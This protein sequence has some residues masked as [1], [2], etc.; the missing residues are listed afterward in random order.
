M[1]EP[2]PVLQE[3]VDNITNKIRELELENTQLWV[4]L[5]CTKQR[6]KVLED[7]GKQVK[8]EFMSNKKILRE[9]LGKREWVGDALVGAN[10]E[11][12]FCNN[13]LDQAYHTIKDLEK[14]VEMSNM[15][16]KEAKEEYEAQ[17]LELRTT[18]KDCR[19]LLAHEKLER[20]NVYRGFFCEQF[21]LRRAYEQIK[22]LKKWIYDQAYLEL[23]NNR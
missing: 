5:S 17:I 18:F 10:S 3:D 16:K 14:V 15:M 12:N 23:Q 13:K 9:V 2:E 21:Q 7:K 22:N 6:N 4:Q 8:E 19:D 1:P 11:L 20:E